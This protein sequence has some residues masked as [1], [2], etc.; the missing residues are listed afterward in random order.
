MEDNKE[1]KNEEKDIWDEKYIHPQIIELN[2]E[3]DV[4][5]D[6]RYFK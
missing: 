3:K 2:P 5:V 6:E 4:I 1:I